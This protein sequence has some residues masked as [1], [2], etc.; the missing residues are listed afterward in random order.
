MSGSA[1]R[2]CYDNICDGLAA[3]GLDERAYHGNV[4]LFMS[5]ALDPETGDLVEGASAAIAGDRIAFRAELPLYVALSVC[6]AGAG[7]PPGERVDSGPV[8]VEVE[9]G[10]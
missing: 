6:P 1:R 8:A 5:A 10:L 2:S 9:L 7:G 4:N 3:V